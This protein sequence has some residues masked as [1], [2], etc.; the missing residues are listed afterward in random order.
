MFLQI[1][2]IWLSESKITRPKG[3]I[4]KLFLK[5]TLLLFF[6]YLLIQNQNIWYEVIFISIF[7]NF[8][9]FVRIVKLFQASSSCDGTVR[10]WSLSSKKQVQSWPWAPRSNDFSNS[11]SL[12]RV[13]FEPITGRFLA[14][15]V[16]SLS[17]VK[18]LE[19]GSWKQV[20]ELEDH[21]LNEVTILSLFLLV[22]IYH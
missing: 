6:V 9:L 4:K 20:A 15:P 21:R 3:A 19:R 8:L 16:H 7:T 12:A 17:T 1:L 13:H 5:V 18:I 22:M 14:V 11:P 10:L 2:V